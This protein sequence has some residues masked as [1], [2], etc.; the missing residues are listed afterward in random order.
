MGANGNILLDFAGIARKVQIM[1]YA[2]SAT[3]RISLIT[4]AHLNALT[5]TGVKGEFSWKKNKNELFLPLLQ[6]R[7]RKC[8]K[9]AFVSESEGTIIIII[10]LFQDLYI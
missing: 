5:R 7:V 8:S 3:C 2:R 1:T 6:L 4:G 9:H 10:Y